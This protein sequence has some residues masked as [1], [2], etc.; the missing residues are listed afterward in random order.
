[1]LFILAT[2]ITG[3]LSGSKSSN[4][5]DVYEDK[6]FLEWATNGSPNVSIE[7]FGGKVYVA[8]SNNDRVTLE[9]TTY[10]RTKR[11]EGFGRKMLSTIQV[12]HEQHGNSSS[13]RIR[14]G[15]DD[16]ANGV[17]QA[18]K[19]MSAWIDL[20]TVWTEILVSVPTSVR[21]EITNWDGEINIGYRVTGEYGERRVEAP[22]F[23][24]RVK[25][26]AVST[27]YSYGT[28]EKIRVSISDQNT[29]NK[30]PKINLDCLNGNIGVRTRTPLHITSRCARGSIRYV[31]PF[32]PGHHSFE[33][34][35]FQLEGDGVE[36]GHKEDIALSLTSPADG[37]IRFDIFSE[38]GDIKSELPVVNK[39]EEAM[40]R[41][42]TASDPKAHVVIKNETPGDIELQFDRNILK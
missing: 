41:V 5:W 30:I 29:T 7:T 17:E 35:P 37:R 14:H 6:Q 36:Y 18:K 12:D 2:S 8:Q 23:V 21:L 10:A 39:D 40:Y 33:V 3:C 22:L 13:V 31:G 27:S 19:R 28:T 24:E 42:Q 38:H 1:M 15:R 11:G 16:A 20:E 26:K 4:S 9:I 25:A 34:L 32:A